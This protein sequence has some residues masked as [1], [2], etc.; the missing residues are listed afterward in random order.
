MSYFAN[1]CLDRGKGQLLH[2]RLADAQNMYNVT[3]LLQLSQSYQCIAIIQY[4][5]ILQAF[6]EVND[7]TARFRPSAYSRQIPFC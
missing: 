7:Q 2:F 4:P 5:M 6:S 3:S 1:F